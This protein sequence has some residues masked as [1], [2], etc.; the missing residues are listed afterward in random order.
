MSTFASLRAARQ[1]KQSKSSRSA[2]SCEVVHILPPNVDVRLSN[3]CG[4][5]SWAKIQH[6]P[7]DILFSLKP[8]VATLSNQHLD[9]YCSNCFGSPPAAGLKRCTS[10]RIVWYCSSAC[11]TKDWLLHKRECVSLQEWSKQ[12]PSTE[13]AIPS[14]AVRCLGRM[15]W[16]KQKRGLDSVWAKELDAM[17][18]HR[19]SLQSS[20][21]ELYTHLSHALVR[22]LG[23]SSPEQLVEFG[24]TSAG[25]LIDFISRFVTNTFTVISPSL[26]PIGAFVPPHRRI[27]KSFLPSERRDCVPSR[28]GLSYGRG[29]FDARHCIA[30]HRTK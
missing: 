22:Y 9:A 26:A 17:Q 20:S 8:H 16:K 25:D 4:R 27:D 5:G 21:F 14:D 10:C 11:Q 15:L 1:S 30:K 29:I 7:G 13:L 12:A 3:T 23:L 2:Q 28:V 6:K 19:T 24:L 18:S